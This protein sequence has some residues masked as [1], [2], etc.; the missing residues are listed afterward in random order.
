MADTSRYAGGPVEVRDENQIA[1]IGMSCRLPGGVY[2][3]RDLLDFCTQARYAWSP[4]PE[5]RFNARAYYHPDHRKEGYVSYT[6][7]SVLRVQSSCCFRSMLVVEP[8]SN[9]M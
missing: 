2:N 3:P 6:L 4:I 5:D 7:L 8:S 9:T 1:I